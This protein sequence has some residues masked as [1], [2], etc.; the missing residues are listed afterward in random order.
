VTP[1]TVK[2]ASRV[3]RVKPSF[4]LEMASKAAEMR[5]QGIDVIN[6][7][8]GEPDFNT[9]DHII[10][11]GKAAMD[12]GFTKYTAGPGMIEL[13]QAICEKLKRENGLDY[14]QLKSLFPMVKSKVYTMFA[15]CCLIKAM[16]LLCFPH[17]GYHSLNL[18]ALQMQNP[19]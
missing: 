16:K 13:R 2:L 4:T 1:Q 9:P 17:I 6:F 5:S 7:S 14:N 3:A 18:Y 8:V 12:E 15:K 11:A 19:F 10:A